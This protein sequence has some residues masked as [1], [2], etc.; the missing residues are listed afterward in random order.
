MEKWRISLLKINSQ[1]KNEKKAKNKK[2]KK[3][4][5]DRQQYELKK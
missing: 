5:E 2:V 3:Y 1:K 4:N